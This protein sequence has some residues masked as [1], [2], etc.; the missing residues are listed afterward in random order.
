[1]INTKHA[2]RREVRYDSLDDIVADA[3]RLVAANAPTTG[4][5][6]KGQILKHLATVMNKSID[7][8]EHMANPL[9]IWFLR[10]TFKKRALSQTMPAGYRLKGKSADELLPSPIDDQDALQQIR[11]AV[12]R[13]HNESQRR[14]NAFLGPLSS[15]EWDQL[16]CR[17]SEMHMSF[18]AEPS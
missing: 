14:P 11:Q 18:I 4:N 5:W 3:E 12:A 6:T 7:G 8:F 17:H 16:H 1:M 13:L 9:L 10:L 2:P 15:E